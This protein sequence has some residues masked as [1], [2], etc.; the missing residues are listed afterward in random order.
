MQ[1]C[2]LPQARVLSEFHHR[3]QTPRATRFGSSNTTDADNPA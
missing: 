3:H 1:I 2:Q